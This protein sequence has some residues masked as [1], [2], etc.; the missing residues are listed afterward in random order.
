[1]LD[2]PE[3][4]LNADLIRTWVG[5][6]TGSMQNGQIWLATHS[7]EAVEA[8]GQEATFVLE[9]NDDTKKIDN[10]ARLDERPVLSALSRAVGTPAFSVSNLAFAFVEG[11][12]GVGERE[13]FRKLVC[14]PSR[15]RF[16][17][18][19]GCQEVL[20]RLVSIKAIAEECEVA[21]RAGGV[22]DRDF[23]ADAD[24]LELSRAYQLFVLPVHE[25]EN[26][27]LHP[28]SLGALLAQN[29]RADVS[30]VDLIRNAA[31]RRAGSWVVQFAR[32]TRNAESLPE[33]ASQ[34]KEL[35]NA[36]KWADLAAER[37][38]VIQRVVNASGYDSGNQTKLKALL[39]IGV[40]A[41]ERAR[42][43]E[44]FWKK[45]EGKQCI[46]DV[47]RDVGFA[48]S[49]ALV[50]AMFALWARDDTHVPAELV[51]LRNYVAG[52]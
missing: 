43:E 47:A 42:N 16:L 7:L 5:Y 1:M 50:R 3:L 6:L 49:P 34:A 52:L 31:D 23:R 10:V 32:A 44:G 35:G 4:H 18:S 24:A 9:R 38:A 48:D 30:A 27:F 14:E 36:I 37:V 25:V 46:N 21:I 33:L 45:C 11:E 41:Y 15:V 28:M 17:E 29:G 13:R 12:E 19:G 20:R 39:E 51:A 26:Y 8:A 40:K 2:E 22:V